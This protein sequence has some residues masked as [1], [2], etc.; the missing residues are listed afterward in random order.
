LLKFLAIPSTPVSKKAAEFDIENKVT[1]KGVTS[2]GC[3]FKD[4]SNKSSII[5]DFVDLTGLPQGPARIK[6]DQK[7]NCYKSGK[8]ILQPL[9]I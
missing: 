7:N 3:I 4:Y 8:K 6:H 2:V 1:N 9:T 5:Y